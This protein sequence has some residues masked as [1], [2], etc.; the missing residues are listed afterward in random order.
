MAVI[1]AGVLAKLFEVEFLVHHLEPVSVFLSVALLLRLL[2]R[3]RPKALH[4]VLL[5][6]CFNV[7]CDTGLVMVQ[8]FVQGFPHRREHLR[9]NA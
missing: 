7:L 8:H 6:G 5:I 2:L 9:G 1:I 4:H 3:V